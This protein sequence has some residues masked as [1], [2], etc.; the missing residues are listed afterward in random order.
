MGTPDSERDYPALIHSNLKD[1]RLYANRNDLIAELATS[2]RGRCI[3]ELGV[4]LG[5][6]SSFLIEALSPS[7]FVA[8]DT[9]DLHKIPI[10]WGQDTST[11]FAGRSHREYFKDRMSKHGRTVRLEEGPSHVRLATYPDEYFSLIYVDAGHDYE[12]VSRDAEIAS[13]K[14]SR[15][16]LL[17]FNDYV[18]YDHV[19]SGMYGVV[20][21]VNEMVVYKGWK[22]VGFAL[23]HRMFCDI[24]IQRV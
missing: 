15:D 21:A 9:F 11:I 3:A 1:A 13:H 6:F 19:Q 16:G 8:F 5:A 17:V 23:Q 7:Q 18:M 14:L 10:L 24:A 22:V 20:P 4:A 12:S 2:A